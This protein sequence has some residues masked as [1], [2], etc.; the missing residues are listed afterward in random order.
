VHLV[1]WG[2][3]RIT[4]IA[5]RRDPGQAIES[6]SMPSLPCGAASPIDN[7]PHLSQINN[8]GTRRQEVCFFQTFPPSVFPISLPSHSVTTFTIHP[9]V[10]L[11]NC[12]RRIRSMALMLFCPFTHLIGVWGAL[13]SFYFIVLMLLTVNAIIFFLFFIGKKAKSLANYKNSLIEF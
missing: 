11:S 6:V 8:V 2:K 5:L 12:Q 1:K 9:I 3:I 13:E 7:G 10:S 4:V